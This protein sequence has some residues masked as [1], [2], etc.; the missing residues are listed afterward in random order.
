MR[1][2]RGSW[3][4]DYLH[5]RATW[6]VLRLLLQVALALGK[7]HVRYLGKL[8][9]ENPLAKSS[10]RFVKGI[11]GFRERFKSVWLYPVGV[12]VARGVQFFPVGL[13]LEKGSFTRWVGCRSGGYPTEK[14]RADRRA[15]RVVRRM[16]I[17]TDHLDLLSL[18]IV[19]SF[20]CSDVGRFMSAMLVAVRTMLPL[21]GRRSPTSRLQG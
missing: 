17:T 13:L 1:A 21:H 15:V 2:L 11:R 6:R 16:L 9:C 8:L 12:A 4:N 10:E 7:I 18:V 3:L 19:V 20:C 5:K 14:P